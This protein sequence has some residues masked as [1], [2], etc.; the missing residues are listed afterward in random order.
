MPALPLTIEGDES[1]LPEL[2]N[3]IVDL[4]REH[5]ILFLSGD[6]GAGK[7]TLSRQLFERLGVKQSVTSPTFNL[8]NVYT[9]ADGK[10]AYHF[11]LYRL[12]HP[13]ELNEIGF[14]EYLYSERPCVI[15]WPEII[16]NGFNEPHLRLR[17]EHLDLGRRY[18]LE[19][20]D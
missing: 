18:H 16:E 9:T 7:T 13:E 17:I 15:E 8:V 19:L 5:P 4:L 12:K 14:D 20:I 3:L 1:R 11:D 10:E 2:V 6:L